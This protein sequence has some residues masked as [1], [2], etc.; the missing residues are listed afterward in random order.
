MQCL[1]IKISLSCKQVKILV[2]PKWVNLSSS[3]NIVHCE[4]FLIIKELVVT[5]LFAKKIMSFIFSICILQNNQKSYFLVIINCNFYPSQYGCDLSNLPLI[6]FIREYCCHH[7]DFWKKNSP[8]IFFRCTFY[9]R[10]KTH[11]AKTGQ[12]T[13]Q[14]WKISFTLSVNEMFDKSVPLGDWLKEWT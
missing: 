7:N 9:K 5:D 1:K 13:V 6:S 14:F 10:G 8:L 3:K 2:H 11:T 4:Q 12:R